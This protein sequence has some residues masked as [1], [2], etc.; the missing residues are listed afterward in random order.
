MAA[1]ITLLTQ[2]D[3]LIGVRTLWRSLQ[4]SGSRYP[5]VVMVTESIPD[6]TRRQ[7]TQ[8]GCLVREVPALQPRCAPGRRMDC[9]L[10]RLPMQP[11]TRGPLSGGLGTRELF[12]QQLSAR[13]TDARRWQRRLFQLRFYGLD[14]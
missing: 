1:W 6:A 9:R 7:L 3:Y 8:E 5:L 12:L 13:P 4:Q 2:P 10:P 14:T 11:E